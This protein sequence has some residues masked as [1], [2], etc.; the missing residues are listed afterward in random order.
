M[1]DL[2]DYIALSLLPARCRVRAAGP[3]R[4]GRHPRRVLEQLV[5][6]HWPDEPERLELVRRRAS[7][8]LRRAREIESPEI[9]AVM[10]GGDD[11]PP[12]LGTIDDPP[13]VL[14]KRLRETP[15]RSAPL[16]SEGASEKNTAFEAPVVALV[17]SRAASPYAIAVAERLAADLAAHG[18][19]VV[20]G[21]ARGVDAA[22]H[23]GA[24][25]GK[26]L[27]IAVLGCGVDVIYPPEH[28]ALARSI[29]LSGMLV[30]ELVPG[31]PPRPWCFPMRNRIISGLSRAVVVIEASEKSGA[32]IT[33]RCALEQG[34]EVLA[35]P[36]NVLN[37]RNRGTHGLLRDGAKIVESA[38]DILEE[39]G[40]R[41]APARSRASWES[42]G[43]DRIL[44]CLAVGAPIDLDSIAERSG[45]TA[46]RILPGLL[47]LELQGVVA[48]VAGGWV[49]QG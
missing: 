13:L 24:L 2:D 8:A 48:R 30:S 44:A 5:S 38:D 22:A 31:T 49:R 21:L 16:V 4:A 23:R 18:V 41:G 40:M 11:Y 9:S 27:T 26:G 36:G 35:V 14:W 32:L 3:L 34:R 19:V 1:S 28:A 39:L 45:L 37:G 7:A 47:E 25:A 42:P 12:M 33:A 46:A 10:F 20:S 6:E 17:G 43:T 29:E 15:E